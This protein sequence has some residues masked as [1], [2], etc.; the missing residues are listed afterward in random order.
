MDLLN[1][2]D[3]ERTGNRDDGQDAWTNNR[4]TG[5]A[6]HHW[7]SSSRSPPICAEIYL[8]ATGGR[9]SGMKWAWFGSAHRS[10]RLD[11]QPRDDRYF[12]QTER[13]PCFG[14]ASR[15]SWG[16]F[17]AVWVISVRRAPIEREDDTV[18]G[19]AIV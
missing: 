14:N 3:T 7:R 10:S 12:M 9:S 16:V 13:R 19:A 2:D 4:W 1:I 6:G 15:T 11:V 5:C 17:L 8:R 18:L